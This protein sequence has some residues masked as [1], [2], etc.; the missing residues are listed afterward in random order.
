MTNKKKFDLEER[1]AKFDEDIIEFAKKESKHWLRMISKA[2]PQLKSEAKILW[3]EAN[4]LNPV[5]YLR[6]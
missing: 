1:T 3:K 5:R 6:Y 2:I 4:E